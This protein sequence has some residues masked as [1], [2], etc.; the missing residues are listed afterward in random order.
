M[1]DVSHSEQPGL[2]DG[3]RA[4]SKGIDYQALGVPDKGFQGEEVILRSPI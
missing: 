2:R 3:K 4:S 1:S